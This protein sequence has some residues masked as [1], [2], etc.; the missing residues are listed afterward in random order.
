MDDEGNEISFV[1]LNFSAL[2]FVSF[3]IVFG[4]F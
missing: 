1:D 2:N 3:K 4:Q